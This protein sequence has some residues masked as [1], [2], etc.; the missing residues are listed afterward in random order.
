ME[1]SGSPAVAT[2]SLESASFLDFN[3]RKLQPSIF[4]EIFSGG[5]C[6]FRL[7]GEGWFELICF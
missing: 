7:K 6:R 1:K 5:C 3:A 2:D 4:N